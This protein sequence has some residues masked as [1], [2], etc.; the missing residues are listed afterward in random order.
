MPRS[1]Y[2]WYWMI[3]FVS[4]CLLFISF[5]RLCFSLSFPFMLLICN[6]NW[7]FSDMKLQQEVTTFWTPVQNVPK[8]PK[9][10]LQYPTQELRNSRTIRLELHTA[11]CYSGTLRLKLHTATWNSRIMRLELQTAMCN[12]KTIRRELHIACKSRTMRLLNTRMCHSRTTRLE[13]HT[14][15][16]TSRTMK[17]RFHTAIYN[18]QTM[19]L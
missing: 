2:V 6:T 7:T 19:S 8:E 17:F 15:M 14:A 10:L 4:A 18:S 12:S 1:A 11:M 3:S 16:C 9:D 13:L 5:R